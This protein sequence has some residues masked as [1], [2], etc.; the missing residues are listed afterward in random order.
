VNLITSAQLLGNLGE[1]VGAIAVVVTL[2]YLA[3]QIRQNTESLNAQSRANY[4]ASFSQL[5]SMAA[6]NSELAEILGKELGGEPLTRAEFVQLAAYFTNTLLTHQWT[7][8]GLSDEESASNLRY[9][10]GSFRQ[11]P[12]LRWVRAHRKEFFRPDFIEYLDRNIVN[13]LDD[14]SIPEFPT[15]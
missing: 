7:Y 8:L 10:S 5:W 14:R 4:H 15:G 2:F 9:L 6:E 13:H 3:S 12:T 11:F 1:F